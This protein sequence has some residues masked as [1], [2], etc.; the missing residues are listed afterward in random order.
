MRLA[1]HPLRD[2]GGRWHEDG[3]APGHGRGR[4]NIVKL[5]HALVLAVAL[6]FGIACQPG[7]TTDDV[8]A[9]GEVDEVD[10]EVVEED[11]PEADDVAADAPE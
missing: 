10:V 6:G 5:V 4:Y 9:I 3:G 7:E 2:D 1:A 11:D 8:S